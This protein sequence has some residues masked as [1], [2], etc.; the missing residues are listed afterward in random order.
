[1]R[2]DLTGQRFGFL[3]VKCFDHRGTQKNP[4][5]Y[6]LCVCDC[7]N[8]VVRNTHQ[9]VTYTRG[10]HT[11][12]CG[13]KTKEQSRAHH[14]TH[15]MSFTPI[16]TAWASM[17]ERCYR[18]RYHNY[19]RYGGRGI[20][21][22]PRWR[23]SFENFYEDMAPTW[24]PGL[25]LDRIDNNGNYEPTNCRWATKKE[26]NNNQERTTRIGGEPLQTVAERSGISPTT[27]HTR[28]RLGVIE[29][30]LLL[31]PSPNNRFTK[32][33]TNAPKQTA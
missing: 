27:L 2:K 3:T 5:A 11:P 10:G 33:K 7:G 1:M 16:H 17:K 12:S 22:C 32:R 18:T 31:P 13:C 26:Q 9:L 25:T 20:E 4:R 14:V 15:G 21:V 30:Q 29:E 28:L 8:E 24:K 19:A 23:D 6:W